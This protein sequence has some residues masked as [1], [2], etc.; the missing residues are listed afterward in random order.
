MRGSVRQDTVEL[1]KW[2]GNDDLPLTPVLGPVN[3]GKREGGAA[4]GGLWYMRHPRF[5]YEKGNR[6][7][8]KTLAEKLD[9]A[10][11]RREARGAAAHPVCV[12]R[13]DVPRDVLLTF[14]W[15]ESQVRLD[16]KDMAVNVASIFGSAEESEF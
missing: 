9:E 1:S 15:F 6:M 3:V 7:Q 10:R 4:H 11:K 16:E 12:C 5:D 13:D 8:E 2:L 14:W